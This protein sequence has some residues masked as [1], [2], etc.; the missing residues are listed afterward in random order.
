M[1]ISVF[2][3]TQVRYDAHKI[4]LNQKNKKESGQKKVQSKKKKKTYLELKKVKSPSIARSALQM[5]PC[6]ADG[7]NA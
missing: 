1:K 4:L 6:T 5:R 7:W 2:C 3:F